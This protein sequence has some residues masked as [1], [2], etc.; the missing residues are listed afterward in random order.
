ML[1]LLCYTS[2]S[3]TAIKHPDK[4][5]YEVLRCDRVRVVGANMLLIVN[6]ACSPSNPIKGAL[7]A[8]TI[9]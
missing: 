8:K 5:R 3:L 4:M 9:Y 2:I 1:L 7:I 6:S